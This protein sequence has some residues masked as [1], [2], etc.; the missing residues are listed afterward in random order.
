MPFYAVANFVRPRT[1]IL[2]LLLAH[3]PG[4]SFIVN[5]AISPLVTLDNWPYN[6]GAGL[7]RVY[8]EHSF[9]LQCVIAVG[10]GLCIF[11]YMHVRCMYV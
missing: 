5:C 1:C 2:M 9:F 3:V 8:C 10:E 6:T 11:K 7:V 4:C